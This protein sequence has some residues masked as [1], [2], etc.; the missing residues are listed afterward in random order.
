MSRGARGAKGV[1]AQAKTEVPRIA[2]AL[3]MAAI[4]ATGV[5][6]FG[7]SLPTVLILVWLESLLAI[8]AILGRSAA[9]RR[10]VR[11]LPPTDASPEATPVRLARRLVSMTITYCVLLGVIALEAPIRA[12]WFG[13]GGAAWA[14]DRAGLAWG[15]GWIALGLV[16]EGVLDHRRRAAGRPEWVVSMLDARLTAL[17]MVVLILLSYTAIPGPDRTEFLV[18]HPNAA[19]GLILVVKFLIDMAPVLLPVSHPTSPKSG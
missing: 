14:L 17:A 2:I 3:L 1:L 6:A 8:P 10:T 15:A 12:W 5:L 11:D 18:E 9:W 13:E 4:P 16:L 7:W 19:L